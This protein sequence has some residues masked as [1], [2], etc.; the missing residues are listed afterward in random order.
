MVDRVMDVIVA[1]TRR[2][3]QR[4]PLD[5]LI[6]VHIFVVEI[7]RDVLADQWI[8]VQNRRKK[9]KPHRVREDV[10]RLKFAE[11]NGLL[12]P[13][14]MEKAGSIYFADCQIPRRNTQAML[15]YVQTKYSVSRLLPLDFIRTT[16]SV[17]VRP[18]RRQ[19]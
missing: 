15:E 3:E 2:Q 19:P 13:V 8:R 18:M 4:T 16:A 10:L 7:R 9:R 1:Q 6:S 17:E 14:T 12:D 11:L 5:I